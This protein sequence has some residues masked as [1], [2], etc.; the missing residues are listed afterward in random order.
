MEKELFEKLQFIAEKYGK[1]S[2]LRTYVINGNRMYLDEI[3]QE[4]K[5]NQISDAKKADSLKE[6][7]ISAMVEYGYSASFAG[8][9]PCTMILN[10][11]II[12]YSK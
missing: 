3:N 4:I 7:I 5:F 2:D 12:K 6:E 10:E 9:I 8:K 1:T 11:Y